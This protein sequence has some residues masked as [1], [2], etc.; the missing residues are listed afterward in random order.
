MKKTVKSV[1]S[2]VLALSV[3]FGLFGCTTT[4]RPGESAVEIDEN[5]SQL[6][7]GNFEGGMGEKWLNIVA[8]NFEK[9]YEDVSFENGKTGVQVHVDSD[10]NYSGD[11]LLANMPTQQQSIYITHTITYQ[12]FI[13]QKVVL[14]ITDWVTED[15]YDSEGNLTRNE[16]GKIDPTGATESIADRMYSEFENYYN[17]G[18]ES[19]PQYYGLPFAQIIG[20]IWYDADLFN[21]KKLYMWD[22]GTFGAQLAD[23]DAQI[24]D[25]DSVSEKVSP[26][27]DGEYGTYDDGLPETWNDF[28]DLMDQMVSIGVTPFTWSGTYTYQRTWLFDTLLASYEGPEDFAL[29]FSLNGSDSDQPEIGNI[30]P[31]TG[32][33]LAKQN[34]RKAAVKIVNDIVKNPDYYSSAAFDGAQSHLLAEREFLQSTRDNDPIAF[35]VEGSFWVSEASAIFEE[36]EADGEQYA[37]ENR[38]FRYFPVPRFTG[39]EGIPEQ[40]NRTPTMAGR[41]STT[42]VLVNA[43]ADNELTKAFVQYM[44]SRESLVIFQ[45]YASAFRPYEYEFTA[46]ELASSTKYTQSMA[47]VLAEGGTIVSTLPKCDEVAAS[48]SFFDYWRERSKLSASESYTTIFDAFR[49]SGVNVENYFAGMYTYAKDNWPVK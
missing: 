38:D 34:G 12:N 40:T 1:I 8:A 47:K 32:Y 22:D 17:V 21:S 49:N 19:S 18:S 2:S 37:Y 29:N 35:L 13:A 9:D 42:A 25:P 31:Q 27:P 24:A 14:D 10:Q 33:E 3:V 15:I 36:M 48:A 16:S 45:Q 28:V 5:K 11:T 4:T 43:K 6:Y 41:L 44:H 39:V 46:E 26:G 7:I 20:G 23:V 30:T